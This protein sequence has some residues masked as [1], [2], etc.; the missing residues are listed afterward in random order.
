MVDNQGQIS[1]PV[2]AARGS[3]AVVSYS[4]AD[5]ATDV[6]DDSNLAT[7][8]QIQISIALIGTIRKLSIDPIVLV[9]RWGITPEKTQKTI[10]ATTQRWIRT[11]LHSSLSR[12]CRMNDHNLCYNYLAHPVFSDT[13]VVSTVSS[14]GNNC[15]E[16]YATDFGWI[17][18]FP[19]ASRSEAHE[20]FS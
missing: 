17:R 8:T 15:G 3:S 14:K 1:I 19:M 9:K 11:M 4:L 18:A 20:T 16:V 13:M 5:D 6:V 2:T 7:E 12:Q 10:Q